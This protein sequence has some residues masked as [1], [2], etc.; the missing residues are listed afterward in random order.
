MNT[1]MPVQSGTMARTRRRGGTWWR[2][3]LLAFGMYILGV[4]IL[5]VTHNP[6]LFPTVSM[7]GSFM[8]PVAYVAFF[9]EHRHLSELSLPTLA[10]TF[11]YGGLLGVFAASILEP[12]F[13]AKLNLL[14]AF[15]VGVIEEFVKILGVLVIARRG[16]HDSQLDGMILGAAA[17]MS[18]AALESMGYA[19][20]ALLRSGGSLSA[21][22]GLTLMRGLLSPLGHGTWTAILVGVLF[23][24]SS[25]GRFRINRAVAGAFLTV[26]VLHALWDGLPD[27]VGQVTGSFL[28]VL[29]SQT[30]IGLVGVFI[31]WRRWREAVRRQ[32][33]MEQIERT[34][35]A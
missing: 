24:E 33:E 14:T 26:V 13:I 8:F 10:L 3:L 7:L 35:Q 1:N 30:V 32:G 4:V 5:F 16:R 15:E 23:R 9:Y 20:S 18:F 19:F 31:L 34:L 2:V 27:L 29:I 6:V 25:G 28:D 17:G 21:T 12:L 22:V 11:L